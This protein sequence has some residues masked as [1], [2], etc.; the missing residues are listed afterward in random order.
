MQKL[1]IHKRAHLQ[2]HK[3]AIFALCRGWDQDTIY[4]S[5]GD[6]LIIAWSLSTLAGKLFAQP[7]KRVL[8]LNSLGENMLF[9]GTLEGDVIMLKENE[10]LQSVRQSHQPIFSSRVVGKNH[11][12]TLDG[13]GTICKWKRESFSFIERT[14]LSHSS[15][16]TV[17]IFDDGQLVI[18]TSDGSLILF[19]VDKMESKRRMT[20]AHTHSI[21]TV[22]TLPGGSCFMSGSKDTTAVIWNQD[23]EVIAILRS[24]QYT[25]NHALFLPEINV[26]ATASKDKTI[27]FWEMDSYT[28]IHMPDPGYSIGHKYSV[29]TL[30][31]IPERRQLISAGDDRSIIIWEIDRS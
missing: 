29:N 17:N 8:T 27:R 22:S 14:R 26:I 19:D 31:W 18:G 13:E 30:L 21:V 15:L 6:G 25:I 5:G 3:A 23:L 4:S 28:E 16:R 12:V 11:F 1:S 10:T 9:A 7:G 20:G 24:H 2:G